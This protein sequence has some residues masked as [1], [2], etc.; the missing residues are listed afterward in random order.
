MKHWH[1]RDS[2]GERSEAEK[3]LLQEVQGA[4]VA[5][6]DT[7]QEVEGTSVFSG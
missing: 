6:S 2:S 3:D 7:V 4:Q 5:Q 1:F